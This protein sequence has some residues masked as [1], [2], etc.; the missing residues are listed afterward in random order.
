MDGYS[1]QQPAAAF[2]D[3]SLS[4]LLAAFEADRK[5]DTPQFPEDKYLAVSQMLRDRGFKYTSNDADRLQEAVERQYMLI[6]L[7]KETAKKVPLTKPVPHKG[8]QSQ[9]IA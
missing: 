2:L 9:K 5:K 8:H 1:E 7:K 6:D 3:Y 4:V